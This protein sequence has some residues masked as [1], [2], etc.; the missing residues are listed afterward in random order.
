SVAEDEEHARKLR[1]AA[2]RKVMREHTYGQRLAYVASRVSLP[3]AAPALPRIAILARAE[4][5]AQLDLL[6]G[7]AMRQTYPGV[8]LQVVLAPG[9]EGNAVAAHPGVR[10]IPHASASHSTIGTLAGQ[11]DMVAGMVPEDYYG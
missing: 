4:D 8:A 2:L 11:S 5:Q 1:L 3:M 6:I 10:L 7:H 9:W